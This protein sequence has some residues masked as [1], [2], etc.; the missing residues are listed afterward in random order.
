MV[1]CCFTSI[2]L[3]ASNIVQNGGHD[4]Q[5]TYPCPICKALK[6]NAVELI[7]K[8]K[9]DVAICSGCQQ[10]FSSNTSLQLT[11][12]SAVVHSVLHA[13]KSIH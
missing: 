7:W 8:A 11:H 6:L 10:N 3:G 4:N 2:C 9:A 1:S 12:A 5:Y 13:F